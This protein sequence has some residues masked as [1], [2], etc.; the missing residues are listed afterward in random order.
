M[1][2]NDNDDNYNRDLICKFLIFEF[3]FPLNYILMESTF[4]ESTF[5]YYL[6]LLNLMREIKFK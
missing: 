5:K 1:Y 2:N 4:K 3:T 6:Q